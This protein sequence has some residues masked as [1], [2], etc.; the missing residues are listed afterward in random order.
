MLEVLVVGGASQ[1]SLTLP[2]T[3]QK[4]LII[5]SHTRLQEPG[6]VF[7]QA[8]VLQNSARYDDAYSTPLVFYL[9]SYYLLRLSA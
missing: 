2:S 3:N 6:L 1:L 8:T 9:F 5:N 4:P 7:L